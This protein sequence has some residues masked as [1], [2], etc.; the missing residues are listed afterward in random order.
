VLLTG[1][2]GFVGM[3]LLVRVLEQTDRDVVALVRA[4]DDDGAR[5]RIDELLKLL[6]EPARRN[7]YRSRVQGVAADL[8]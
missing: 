2:T 6:V 7:A 3:E 5:V 8:E 4:A 1:A